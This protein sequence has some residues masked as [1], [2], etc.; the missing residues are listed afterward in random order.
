MPPSSCFWSVLMLLCHST[1]H[2]VSNDFNLNITVRSSRN[3]YKRCPKYMHPCYL[4]SIKY[5]HFLESSPLAISSLASSSFA[6]VPSFAL[7]RLDSWS[8][9]WSSS[10]S[11]L[12]L[13]LPPVGLLLLPSL[14]LPSLVAL[15]L[16]PVGLLLPFSFSCRTG[17]T[18][19]EFRNFVANP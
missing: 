7:F 15:L 11:R 5:P 10:L 16:P 19:S 2:F 18:Q 4:I 8:P 17:L 6:F 14:S 9:S 13:L 3:H 12:L 1:L